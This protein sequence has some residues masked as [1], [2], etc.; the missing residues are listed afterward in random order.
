[1]QLSSAVNLV[2]SFLGEIIFFLRLGW[3]PAGVE[4]SDSLQRSGDALPVCP[5]ET[6]WGR[7]LALHSCGSKNDELVAQKLLYVN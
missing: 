5:L 4:K 1:M 2:A 7:T 6:K 3:G